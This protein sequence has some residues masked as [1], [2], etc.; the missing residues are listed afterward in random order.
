[1]FDGLNVVQ[2]ADRSAKTA[3][4]LVPAVT[5]A[6]SLLDRLAQER[7]PMALA[8][9]ASALELPKSSVHGLCNTLLSLGYLRRNAEGSFS[10]GPRV[11]GLADAFIADTGVVSEFAALWSD[12][13]P[14]PDETVVLTILYGADVVYLATRAGRRPLG[15][16]FNIGMRLPAHLAASGKAMLAFLDESRLRA[17]FEGRELAAMARPHAPT[18]DALIDELAEVRRRGYSI[19]DE[20]V[21][22]GVY[23]IGAP[24][25]DSHGAAV[26]GVGMCLQ[27]AG[28]HA[29]QPESQREHV[30]DVA[31]RLTQRLGG[32]R[33]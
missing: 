19:D 27:K 32:R 4:A 21:R 2:Q 15:L 28:R 11:M 9:L 14:A 12:G 20:S 29:R 3:P 8:R 16:Q 18:V 33:P 31:Q 6:M 17:L 1:V 5:R 22:E 7:Q 10:I 26:A 25:F 13:G 30:V 23:C 24:V